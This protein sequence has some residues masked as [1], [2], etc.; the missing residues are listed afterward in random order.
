MEHYYHTIQGHFTY[1]KFYTDTINKLDNGAKIV[2][3]GVWKGQSVIYAGVEIYNSGKQI[4]IDCVDTFEGSPEM[5]SEPLLAIKDGLYNHFIENIE[6]LKNIL[7]PIR[8]PSVRAAILYKDKTLDCVFIDAAHDFDNVLADV[9]AW[10]PKV[11]QG[12]ILAGHDIGQNNV[13]AAVE[14]IIGNNYFISKDEDIWIH[15]VN[16]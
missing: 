15:I 7:T 11:K 12:G 13:R 6:P 14:V 9:R 4:K 5:M 3:V 16:S 8:L 2:E 10:L 1:P